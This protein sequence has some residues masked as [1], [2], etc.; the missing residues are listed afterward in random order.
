[1][2]GGFALELSAFKTQRNA[3]LVGTVAD[4]AEPVFPRYAA[5]CT[6]WAG[7]ACHFGAFLACY[8]ANSNLHRFASFTK[9]SNSLL[10]KTS[11]GA[12]R[13]E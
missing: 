4:L 11:E 8:T 2:L 6:V 10:I 7:S 3:F 1:M 12:F 13:V 5:D 9:K